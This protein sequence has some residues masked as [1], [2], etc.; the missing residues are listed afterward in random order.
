MTKNYAAWLKAPATSLEIIPAPMPIAR[1][2][3]VIVRARAVA[4]NPIDTLVQHGDIDVVEKYPTILGH[5]V[6]GEIVSV[7]A[8]VHL[9][10][11][12]DRVLAM[13]DGCLNDPTHA[14][15]QRFVAVNQLSVS[16]IPRSL[17]FTDATVLPLGLI[18]AAMGLFRRD[19]LNLDLPTVPVTNPTGKSILIWG[20][21]SSVG[22]NAIQLCVA[23]GY[24]VF[25]TASSNN[26]L[27]L[28][29]L[30]AKEVFDYKSE[31]VVEQV[32][33]AL[34]ATDFVG[35]YCAV[36]GVLSTVTEIVKRTDGRQLMVSAPFLPDE[37]TSDVE[38]KWV[39]I[40]IVNKSSEVDRVW[41]RFLARIFH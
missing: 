1:V 5:D 40:G 4:I 24:D 7:G 12:G 20:G 11:V 37:Y 18:T 21:A 30:G 6:A 38:T 14:A 39:D 35:A 15:F 32:V 16:K 29:E 34:R 33:L 19:L 27:C 17:S 13:A 25:T 31:N 10:K 22:S 26:F 2:N 23:A 36:P 28:Q 41:L 3:E 9:V 8:N